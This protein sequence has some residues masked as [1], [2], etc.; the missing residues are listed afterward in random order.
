MENRAWAIIDMDKGIVALCSTG[1][2]AAQMANEYVSANYPVDT[3]E[4]CEN[5]EIRSIELDTWMDY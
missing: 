5:V 2:M 1:L 3:I 4:E